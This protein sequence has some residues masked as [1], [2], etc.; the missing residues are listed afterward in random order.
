[1][2]PTFAPDATISAQVTASTG[3]PSR[4]LRS[5]ISR[6]GS[7]GVRMRST[8]ALGGDAVA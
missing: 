1:V 4:S 6:S 2:R 7:P 3:I 5:R 8:P